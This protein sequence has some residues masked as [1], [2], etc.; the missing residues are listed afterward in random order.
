MEERTGVDPAL[1]GEKPQRTRLAVREV[2]G[3]ASKDELLDVARCLL[4]TS[5][6]FAQSSG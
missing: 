6:H 1:R 3:I 4:K 5:V 2:V